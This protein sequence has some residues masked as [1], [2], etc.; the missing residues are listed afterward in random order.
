MSRWCEFPTFDVGDFQEI[1]PVVRNFRF[2]LIEN[3]NSQRATIKFV[4]A[5]LRQFPILRT[6]VF[7]L[8]S[9]D[10]FI[11]Q[12]IE[13]LPALTTVSMQWCKTPSRRPPCLRLQR[14]H[15]DHTSPPFTIRPE[16]LQH[17]HITD[18]KF[19]ICLSFLKHCACPSLKTLLL[20][21][22]VGRTAEEVVVDEGDL[23]AFPNLEIYHGPH[24]LVTHFASGASLLRVT[25]QGTKGDLLEN[26]LHQLH[27][28]APNLVALKTEVLA[29]EESVLRA[30]CLF[31][32][33]EDLHLNTTARAERMF[34]QASST[35]F[36]DLN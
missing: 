35:P 13:H 28:L 29:I 24:T 36:T 3:P 25:L 18:A 19:P 11:M 6:L 27:A 7:P 10:A 15:L 16:L 22:S 30:A 21:Q 1:A 2:T 4:F 34:T 20:T 12:E 32:H 17:L 9:I 33:L 23:P 5:L 26:I 31:L 14:L 8:C